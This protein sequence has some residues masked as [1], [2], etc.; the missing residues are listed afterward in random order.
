MARSYFRQFRID[1][2][3]L[4]QINREFDLVRAA[5][6]EVAADIAA[7]KRPVESATT[8]VPG[9]PGPAGDAG[10]EVWELEFSMGYHGVGSNLIDY[11]MPASDG[12]FWFTPDTKAVTSSVMDIFYIAEWR[13]ERNFTECSL[14]LDV[15]D[16][17]LGV[18]ATSI[19]IEVVKN[20]IAGGT[21]TGIGQFGMTSGAY[22]WQSDWVSS[23]L[24]TS[25]AVGLRCKVNR[26]T[27][28]PPSC[29]GPD[30]SM[31]MTA[32]IIYR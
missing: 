29:P 16:L 31:N 19:D 3:T 18:H 4:D 21:P 11:V 1:K 25:D 20:S 12:Y 2:L 32:K 27:D 24:T 14:T 8:P 6:N 5:F 26:R 23:P 7:L 22:H 9:P 10:A 30:S 15:N 13:P 28:Y 17:N